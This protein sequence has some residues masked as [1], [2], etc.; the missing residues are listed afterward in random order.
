MEV[1]RN[2]P[3]LALGAGWNYMNSD[4]VSLMVSENQF[5]MGFLTVSVPN[6]NWC[7]VS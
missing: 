1:G 3:T 7:G 6:S 4:N 5:G 2:L